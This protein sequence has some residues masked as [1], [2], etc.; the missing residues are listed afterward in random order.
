M[1]TGGGDCPGLNAALRGFGRAAISRFGMEVLGFLDGFRGIVRDRT[2]KLDLASLSGILTD[3]GTILGTSRDKVHRYQVDGETRD[4]VPAVVE[5]YDREGLDALIMLGG[6]GTAKNAMRLVD[7]G[8]NVIH[9]P[10][11]IDNDIAMTDTTFGFATAT[12]IATAPSPRRAT[13]SRR[14]FS[15]RVYLRALF[16]R[17]SSAWASASLSAVTRGRSSSTST[18]NRNPCCSI[19]KRYASTT[20]P[21]TR[22]TSAEARR[23]SLRPASMREKS[24]MLL[25]SC[26]S[27]WLSLLMTR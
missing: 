3:G 1:L 11:T 22:P 26:V 21:T 25:M 20:S 2:V 13:A 9:L 4:M 8:L 12:E 5:N 6:G 14:Y 27:R 23:Y 19:W 17:F 24:R 18:S 16:T 15:S 7:A 10:K